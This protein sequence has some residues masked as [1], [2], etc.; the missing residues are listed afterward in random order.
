MVMKKWIVGD[1]IELK[2]KA[3]VIFGLKPDG[4]KGGGMCFKTEVVTVSKD[5]VD[6]GTVSP[7]IGG[8]TEL[9]LKGADEIWFISPQAIWAA[10]AEALKSA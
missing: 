2:L 9:Y 7:T 1:E 3:K 6:I 10:F 8:G 4:S 5:G